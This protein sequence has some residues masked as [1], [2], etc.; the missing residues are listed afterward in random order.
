MRDSLISRSMGACRRA[1]YFV[2][3][4]S[5]G[6]NIL[7]LSSAIYMMQVYDR[8]LTT[9]NVDTLIVLSIIILFALVV[10]ALLDGIR[11]QTMVRIGGWLDRQLSGATLASSISVG[12]VSGGSTA[13]GLRDLS[14][15]RGY[16]ASPS[17]FPL[18]DAPFAP[19]FLLA[20][21]LIHP[22]LGWI[23]VTG[24]V[25]LF[26]FGVIND[27][28]TK[29]A[30]AESNSANIAALNYADTAV[31]NADA[32]EAMGMLPGLSKKYHAASEAAFD[33]QKT[34]TDR[35]GLL[36][37]TAKGLR[38]ILQSAILGVGAWLVIQ[39][40]MTAGVMIA[41]SIIMGRAL[42]PVEQSITAWRAFTIAR[43][44]YHRLEK[45]LETHKTS[46]DTTSLPV[47][48]GQL[49]LEG[50]S[51]VPPGSEKAIVNNIT[52]TLQAGDA[53][54]LIGPSASGKSTLG[55]MIVGALTPTKGAVRL[56][57]ANVATWD[58]VDRGPHIGY[59]PQEIEFFDGTIRENI[60]RLTDASDEE[61][62]EAAQLAGVHEMILTL[63]EGYESNIGTN[64]I[65][66]SGGQRQRLALARA[67]F[68]KPKLLL[69]DEP[70]SNLDA[71]GE[72]KLVEAIGHMRGLGTTIIVIA[73]RPNILAQMDLVLVLKEGE[74]SMF[75]ARD[76]VLEQIRAP[77]RT[78]PTEV[79]NQ[80]LGSSAEGK[81]D[82]AS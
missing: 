54:G 61:I 22:T 23:A 45:H 80:Q 53:L 75:G 47:P 10:L 26:V 19:I 65:R 21:F 49:Q 64:G 78:V 36:S 38:L 17:V 35:S 11:N 20:I 6:I 82:R 67:V 39:Q 5:L 46:E 48:T 28:V 4:I 8:V 66:L 68:R 60:A 55:R 73:H 15:L 63:P 74:A 37:S 34:A 50:V 32:I 77:L 24:A 62:V 27:R 59:L 81:K 79:P 14:S 1:F 31:R 25:I 51:Y 44:T 43:E 71:T 2:A 42:A 58:A 52:G 40:E 7:M 18:F 3:V 57:G 30:S 16:M 56:D 72:Q 9:R 76:Q 33:S 29:R 13:Q 69:L 12:L 70:N 41:A